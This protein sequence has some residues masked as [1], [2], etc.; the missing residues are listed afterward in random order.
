MTPGHSTHSG[1]WHPGFQAGVGLLV[2]MLLMAVPAPARGLWSRGYLAHLPMPTPAAWQAPVEPPPTP[3][4]TEPGI[5]SYLDTIC[6]APEVPQALEKLDQLSL[7]WARTEIPWAGIEPQRDHFTWQRWDRVVDGLRAH[8][9]QVLGMLCYWTPWAQPYSDEAIEAFGRYAE[10]VAR[11]YRGRVAAWEIWNEPNERTFWTSTPERYVRLMRAAYEGVKRGDPDALVIGGSL[12]GV[13]LVYLRTLL[14]LGAGAWMDRLSVH[15]YSFGWTPEDAQ[16]LRE[17]RGIAQELRRAGKSDRLWVTE[18]GI[19]LSS[20]K[21]QALLLERTW[22]LL[23]QSGVVE[24]AFWFN[25]YQPN[26]RTYPLYR[27]DW[28]PTPSA[29]ALADVTTRLRGAVPAG[30]AWPRDLQPPWASGSPFALSPPQAW[31]YR[32]GSR[33]LLGLWVPTGSVEFSSPFEPGRGFM[34]SRPRW[35]ADPGRRS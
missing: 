32:Q 23:S 35:S 14:K 10:R 34:T 3:A 15:P 31:W 12:S 11:R 2:C 16:L 7:G 8:D 29:R 25:L 13:D 28:S 17:L 20:G 26:S 21:K 30:S 33:E 5:G 19:N 6:P 27:A 4:V 22:A 1:R 9:Y 24:R 18:I